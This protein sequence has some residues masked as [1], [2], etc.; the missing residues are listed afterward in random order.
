MN[1]DREKLHQAILEINIRRKAGWSPEW[2]KHPGIDHPPE[3][4][5]QVKKDYEYAI[6]YYRRESSRCTADWATKLYALKAHSRGRQ[7]LHKTWAANNDA[8]GGRHLETWTME[9]QAK[10][11]EPL[12]AEFSLKETEQLIAGQDLEVVV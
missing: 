10:F 1:I 8:A 3:T 5:P 11:I 6:A 4:A 12:L 7:H 9:D 2:P